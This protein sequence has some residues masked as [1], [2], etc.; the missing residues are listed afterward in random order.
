MSQSFII[1]DSYSDILAGYNAG[2]KTIGVK[3]GVG[4]NEED[5]NRMISKG[6]TLK[7]PEYIYNNLLEAVKSIV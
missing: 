5:R 6:Y 4:L 7:E 1:G 3:T 2:V